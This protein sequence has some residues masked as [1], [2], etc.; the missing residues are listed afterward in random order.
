MLQ[1]S[2][3]AWGSGEFICQLAPT[4]LLPIPVGLSNPV[5]CGV[6]EL[7][8]FNLSES[9]CLLWDDSIPPPQGPC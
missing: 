4:A 2:P 8:M 9:C 7:N 1:E 3:V 5:L 6:L